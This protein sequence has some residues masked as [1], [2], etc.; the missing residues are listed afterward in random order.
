M[1]LP[2][3]LLRLSDAQL[4]T[5]MAACRPLPPRLRVVF[6][7]QVAATL[8]GCTELGDG[9]VHRAVR[10]LQRQYWDPPLATGEE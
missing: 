3:T 2:A 7:E 1:S 5:I 8:A 9:A 10:A 4:T 6:L